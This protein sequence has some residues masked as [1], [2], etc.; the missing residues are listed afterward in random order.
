MMIEPTE[1]ES[2]QTLDAFIDIM[3][4]IDNESRESPD[5]V[6]NAPYNTPVGR[7]DEA[8]AARKPN[9]RWQPE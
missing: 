9:L 8:L 1:T 2:R 6:R 7:L 3:L 4:K 5:S